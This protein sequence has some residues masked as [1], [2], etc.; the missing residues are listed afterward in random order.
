MEVL[1]KRTREELEAGNTD[2]ATQAA[3]D[4]L[5]Q[6]KIVKVRRHVQATGEVK[7]EVPAKYTQFKLIGDHGAKPAVVEAPKTAE[8]AKK[9]EEKSAP[10][11][12]PI[13]GGN[14]GGVDLAKAQ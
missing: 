5:Q 9:E 2:Q 4:I 12:K 7:S 14:F 3:L 1:K 6:R 8:P 13:Q 10:L 11:F